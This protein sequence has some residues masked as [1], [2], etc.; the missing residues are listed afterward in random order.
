MGDSMRRWNDPRIWFG[1]FAT[2]LCGLF[3]ALFVTVFIRDTFTRLFLFS[4]IAIL[5]SSALY[6][7]WR[8]APWYPTRNSDLERIV[9]LAD[10]TAE[11]TF[12]DL[13]CGNG[14]VV[15][16]LSKK[17]SA[18]VVGI[19]LSY[20]HFG[21]AK[22]R[23]LFLQRPNL[24]ILLGDMFRIDLSEADVVYFYGIRQTMQR[25]YLKEILRKLRPGTRLLAYDYPIEEL[26]PTKID[27]AEGGLPI[28]VYDLEKTS[29]DEQ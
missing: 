12:Y 1:L 20:F 26:S 10:L 7:A 19:E 13:G 22:L 11:K 14:R 18:R 15:I 25:P 23:Q 5:T 2:L 9:S 17:T 21:L 27:Q 3:P 24:H 8:F 29:S 4:L 16:Y 6:T 28:Y